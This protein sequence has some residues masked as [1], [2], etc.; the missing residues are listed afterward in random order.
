MIIYGSREATLPGR[1]FEDGFCTHCGQKGSI[2][3]TVYSR[4]AH[5]F[6]IPFF[7]YSKRIEIH[8]TN[9]GQAYHLHEINQPL[10]SEIEAFYRKKKAPL[11]QW[12]GLLLIAASIIINIVNTRR[13]NSNTKS[14]I[15][16]PQINDVYCIKYDNGYS[17]MYIDDIEEDSI[18]FIS[19]DYYCT[20]FSDAK[21]LHQPQYYESDVVYGFS[22]EELNAL[23][24]EEKS[25]KNIWRNLPYSHKELKIN[26]TEIKENPLTIDT[27]EE[28]EEES[29]DEEEENRNENENNVN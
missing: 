16:A 12:T 1:Q 28:E 17:L 29:E 23:F 22:R 21:K 26:S 11:W 15:E 24:Y 27:Y 25:I 9:C 2:H 18:F 4:H 19:S 20:S 10:Q 14:F 6:W 7:P 5:L 13:E 3:A 8:C